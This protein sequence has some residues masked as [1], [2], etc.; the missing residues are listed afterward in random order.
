MY[1]CEEIIIQWTFPF[2]D[3]SISNIFL[4]THSIL[5]SSCVLWEKWFFKNRMSRVTL[6]IKKIINDKWCQHPNTA[7]NYYFPLLR[8]LIFST[9]EISARSCTHFFS[10]VA[11]EL[12]IRHKWKVTWTVGRVYHHVSSPIIQA[13]HQTQNKHIVYLASHNRCMDNTRQEIESKGEWKREFS[14][15]W[16]CFNKRQRIHNKWWQK[17]CYVCWK[18]KNKK[19]ML[20][21]ASES[22]CQS[23]CNEQ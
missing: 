7:N 18:Q 3:I 17:C 2:S 5:G 23:T 8:D 4:M 10:L 20:F 16:Y 22:F 15:S 11:N 14:F 21:V 9:S 12:K 13:I 6:A 1:N 19:I